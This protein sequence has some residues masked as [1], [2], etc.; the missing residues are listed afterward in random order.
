MLNKLGRFGGV[1]GSPADIPEA[2]HLTQAGV[3]CWLDIDADKLKD[4]V[5]ELEAKKT[6][7][8]K[9]IAQLEGRLANKS[10]VD[11]APEKVVGETRQQLEAAKALLESIS[12]EHERF[13][14]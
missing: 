5:T 8:E 6:A 11:N 4:Y 13:A 12:A 7:Q 2:V 1:I 3:L 9:V 14:S 10:Y